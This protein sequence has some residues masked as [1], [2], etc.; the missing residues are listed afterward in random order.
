MILASVW[1]YLFFYIYILHVAA[2]GANL[3]DNCRN[4]ELML[5][6]LG[7]SWS[8]FHWHRVG[9]NNKKENYRNAT[10]LNR[11]SNQNLM[12][13]S[14][15]WIIIGTYIL[16]ISFFSFTSVFGNIFAI[17]WLLKEFFN[18]IKCDYVWNIILIA[19]FDSQ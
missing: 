12:P 11:I 9:N 15:N 10:G 17:I 4:I 13:H 3:T 18:R 7:E 19:N 6:E 16:S 2:S 14:L 8:I 1:L 5:S